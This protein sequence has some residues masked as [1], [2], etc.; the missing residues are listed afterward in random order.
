MID[1]FC[2]EKKFKLCDYSNR[3]I[4]KLLALNK[5]TK[6]PVNIKEIQKAIYYAKKYHGI[7]KRE[8]G[9]PYYSHPIEVAYQ[10]SDYAFTTDILITSILHDTIEDTVMTKEM[11]NYLF[12]PTIANN[13]FNLTRISA[14]Q[15][16]SVSKNIKTLFLNGRNDLLLIKIFDRLHNLQ[17][18]RVKSSHK[19]KKTIYETIKD[20][21]IVG[22]HLGNILPDTMKIEEKITKLCYQY[23]EIFTKQYWLP[24]LR[25]TFD[26]HVQLF[27]P[28]FQNDID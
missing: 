2:W 11:I 28:N 16:I 27:F 23:I 3:L 10:V 25:M 14:N 1:L 6:Y 15:N 8:T 13:V 20:F 5:V 17:T 19:I 26:D 12:T 9:E 21:I 7:Q 4:T 22:I 18:L 24:P